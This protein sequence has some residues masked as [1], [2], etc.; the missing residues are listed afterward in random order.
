[1]EEYNL[2]DKLY[3][4][5]SIGQYSNILNMN[6]LES[7]S[8]S[9]STFTSAGI[10][11]NRNFEFRNTPG[12]DFTTSIRIVFNAKKLKSIIGFEIFV[13]KISMRNRFVKLIFN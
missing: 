9:R 2:L 8:N 6:N 3:W 5:I 4:L 11:H 13:F 7:S 1:M 12:K 10:T